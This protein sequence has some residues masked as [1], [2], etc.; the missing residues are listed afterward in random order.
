MELNRTTL[1]KIQHLIAANFAGRDELY[2]A[3]GS[4]DNEAR[5]RVCHRL[6][7]HLAGHAVELQQILTASGVQPT[8]PIDVHSLAQAL[9]ESAKRSRGEPGV[10]EAAVEREQTLKQDYDRALDNLSHPQAENVLKRQRDDVEFGEQVLRGM[11]GPDKQ[12]RGPKSR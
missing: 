3:A 7:E 5:Q 11:R 9:F 4:L 10:L 6:A 2:A 8:G 12:Q 1:D